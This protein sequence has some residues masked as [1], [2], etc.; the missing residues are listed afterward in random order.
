MPKR[1]LR[2]SIG[3]KGCYINIVSRP[4]VSIRHSRS[5]NIVFL[6]TF[7]RPLN[8][9]N[10]ISDTSP[11][12]S[13]I[14]PFSNSVPLCRFVFIHFRN[15]LRRTLADLSS[16]FVRPPLFGRL[17]AFLHGPPRTCHS[18]KTPLDNYDGKRVKANANETN[19]YLIHASEKTFPGI[20]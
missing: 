5:V 16:F 3:Y 14:L 19:I 8:R 6:L 9:L 15:H 7:P 13:R 18:H 1:L 12:P 20:I 17:R 10:L 4:L 11:P 2:R